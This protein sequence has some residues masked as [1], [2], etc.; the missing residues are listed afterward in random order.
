MAS[1]GQLKKSAFAE[2]ADRVRRAA[3]EDVFPGIDPDLIEEGVYRDESGDKLTR[4]ATER[5]TRAKDAVAERL[6]KLA[7]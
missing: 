5:L 1:I 6:E 4:A 7:E 3:P 2:L